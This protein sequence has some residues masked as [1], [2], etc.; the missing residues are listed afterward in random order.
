V[1]LGA[2]NAAASPILLRA[3]PQ[4]YLGRAIATITPVQQLASMASAIGAGWLVSTAWRDFHHVVMGVTFGRIDTVYLLSGLAIVISGL[5]ATVALT[6]ADA[7]PAAGD[8]VPER[9]S[10]AGSI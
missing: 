9:A 2:I 1:P 8:A 7:P 3:T 5:Y 10:R 4:E 6:R